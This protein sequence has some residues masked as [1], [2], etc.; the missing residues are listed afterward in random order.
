MDVRARGTHAIPIALFVLL[1]GCDGRS[2]SPTSPSAT[3]F[4]TGTWTGTITIQVNPGDPDAPP[5]T[6]G[7]MTWIFAVVPQTDL[8]TF[9]T[10]IRSED[11][12]LTMETTA[13]TA[14]TPSNT[15]PHPSARRVSTTPREGVAARS[16][17][18]ARRRPRAS[19]PTSTVATASWRRSRGRWC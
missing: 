18:S 9:T 17:A 1:A 16:L 5:P 11:P 10:T 12:W 8:R 14:L 19:R 6:S 7:L 4:L 2:P 15:P 13:S 3:S